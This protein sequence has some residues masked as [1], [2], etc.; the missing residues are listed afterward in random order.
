MSLT[1]TDFVPSDE[2]QVLHLVH[3]GHF[4]SAALNSFGIGNLG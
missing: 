1:K 2:V 4:R 3:T